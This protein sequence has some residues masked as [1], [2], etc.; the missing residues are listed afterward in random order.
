MSFFDIPFDLK[1][2]PLE[3]DNPA[4]G[5]RV[6][7]VLPRHAGTS[8][9][10]SLYLPED[11]TPGAT[12]PV[13]VEYPGN[14]GYRE[15]GA[16]PTTGRLEDCPLGYGISAGLGF[17]WVSL[18]FVDLAAGRQAVNWWGDVEATVLY[19]RETVATVC[20]LY[21]G[22]PRKVLLAG[23]SRGAIACNFIGLHDDEIS[24]LWAGFI[25]HSH[26]EG[27]R[28]WPQSD[29]ASALGRLSR[30]GDRPVWISHENSVEETSKY[31]DSTG[32][33]AP[34]TLRTFPFPNHTH[35]WVLK[36]LPLRAELRAWVSRVVG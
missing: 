7:Q 25:A 2:P 8:L 16:V 34:F 18:P 10:H 17:I 35:D 27:V 29:H 11:W 15:A 5:R 13:I 9:Y 36:D 30:L 21:G 6:R 12:Y 32:V 4:P 33:T 24:K 26:Y 23:F 1:L 14:G 22:D 19:C 28:E 20:Q 31:L 3:T